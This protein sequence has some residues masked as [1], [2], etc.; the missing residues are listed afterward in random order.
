GSTPTSRGFAPAKIGPGQNNLRAN[1]ASAWATE[2]EYCRTSP[3]STRWPNSSRNP[4]PAPRYL[5]L[6]LKNWAANLE[7]KPRSPPEPWPNLNKHCETHAYSAAARPGISGS[8]H[9]PSV[10]SANPYSKTSDAYLIAK[11]NAIPDMPE[12]PASSPALADPGSLAMLSHGTSPAPSPTPL[13]E[14]SRRAMIHA[15]DYGAV[16]KMS[17]SRKLRTGPRPR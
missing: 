4:T 9:R 2:P 17:N 10:A 1:K 7:T 11:A 13:L 14:R 12:P 16:S 8:P 3:T 5:T 6:T 15:P